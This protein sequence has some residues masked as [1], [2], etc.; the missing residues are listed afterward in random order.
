LYLIYT[1]HL[2]KLSLWDSAINDHYLTIH[3]VDKTTQLVAINPLNRQKNQLGIHLTTCRF[4]SVWLAS[5]LTH[6]N[7][8]QEDSEIR[9]SLIHN[10]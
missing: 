1:I 5:I 4:V 8:T 3:D 10:V 7:S 2:I 6:V 9:D